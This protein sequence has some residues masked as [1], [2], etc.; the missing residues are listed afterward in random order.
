MPLNTRPDSRQ[1]VQRGNLSRISP[2]NSTQDTVNSNI[3]QEFDYP[4]RPYASSPTPDAQ[5]N[6]SDSVVAAADGGNKV[7][8]PIAN[9]VFDAL[10]GLFINF[11]T[12]AVSNAADFDITWPGTNNVGQF[13]RVGLSLIDTGKILVNFSAEFASQGALPDPGTLLTNG[14]PIGYV[15]LECTNVAG[16]FKTAGSATNVIEDEGIFRIAPGSGSAGATANAGIVAEASIG[17]AQTSLSVVFGSPLTGSNYVVMATMVN[18]V[19]GSVD[20]QPITVTA[21]SA[22]GFTAKWNAPTDS[23]NYKLAYIIP[24]AQL[25]TTEEPVGAGQTSVTVNLPVVRPNTNYVVVAMLV[26]LV[27]GSP[28]F[29]PVIITAKTTTT[30]TAKWNGPTD[31]ANYR[32][33]FF[34]ADFQ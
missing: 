13:R 25:A 33:A 12:Q 9:Q 11:Q 1:I 19:D 29:Q 10:S 15:D 17:S 32:L 6:F 7:V 28:Q 8:A 26:D 18:T 4:L 3:N 23:A 24:N 14:N 30:F 2:A 20:Y 27:D 21:K 16:Y 22:S 5:L 31:S 34:V